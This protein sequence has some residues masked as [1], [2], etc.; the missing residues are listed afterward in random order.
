MKIKINKSDIITICKTFY[1]NYQVSCV[2]ENCYE[3]MLEHV[4][5]YLK[6]INEDDII[7]FGYFNY[8]I[9]NKQLLRIMDIASDCCDYAYEWEQNFIN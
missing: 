8:K 7:R 4:M 5:K 1:E 6:L 3:P 9:S 2:Y